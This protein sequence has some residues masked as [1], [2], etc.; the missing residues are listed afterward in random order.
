MPYLNLIILCFVI[1][2]A[3][4][5]VWSTLKTGISPMMS[6]R[7]AT[8]VILDTLKGRV[9]KNELWVDLGSGWGT[10]VI[11]MAQ[12]FPDQQVIGYEL[13]WFPWVVSVLRKKYLGLDNLKLYKKNFLEAELN[14]ASVLVCY[15]YPGGMLKLSEKL[16]RDLVD[17]VMIVSN[18]FALSG[19]K[20]SKTIK[21]KDIYR[22]PIYLYQWSKE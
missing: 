7:K 1:M 3:I 19:C 15:L 8:G 10:L 5:I 13:S 16:K 20:S 6:S 9:D 12:R 2:I 14:G 18:T 22:T 11:G 17:D 21:L 4:S